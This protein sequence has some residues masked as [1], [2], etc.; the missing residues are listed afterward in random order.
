MSKKAI[1]LKLTRLQACQ[2]YDLL[3]GLNYNEGKKHGEYGLSFY[4]VMA[5]VTDWYF[6]DE[7][8]IERFRDTIVKLLEKE[9]D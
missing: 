1:T 3:Q 9:L 2:L 4:S 8:H 5:S 6:P 7:T